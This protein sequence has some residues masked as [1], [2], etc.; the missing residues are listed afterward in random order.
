MKTVDVTL[1]DKAYQLK[2]G[3]SEIANL[4][5]YFNKSLGHV[6]TNEEQIGLETVRGFYFAGLKW[7]RFR[8]MTIDLLDS[9]LEKHVDTMLED[10]KTYDII[11]QELIEPC[12]QL[13]KDRGYIKVA[14]EQKQTNE[15]QE[16]N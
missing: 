8:G 6:L 15:V 5:K 16:K 2:Y 1:A 4:E 9:I 14:D 13:L 12:I 11:L 10:G 3:F 7:G